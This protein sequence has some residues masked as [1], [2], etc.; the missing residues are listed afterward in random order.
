[1]GRAMSSIAFGEGRAVLRGTSRPLTRRS[2]GRPGFRWRSEASFFV[3]NF[4]SSV[5]SIWVST[6]GSFY[7]NSGGR[8]AES[9]KPGPGREGAADLRGRESEVEGV[10]RPPQ[11]RPFPEAKKRRDLRERKRAGR[12][13]DP[14]ERSGAAQ[15]ALGRA[16]KLSRTRVAGGAKEGGGFLFEW[17]RKAEER[18][19]VAA[20]RNPPR[21]AEGQREKAARE[22]LLLPTGLPPSENLLRPFPAERQ[23]EKGARHAR[24]RRGEAGDQGDSA[25][26]AR[27][28]APKEG[29]Q[30]ADAL[31]EP[32]GAHPAGGGR[33]EEL[34]PFDETPLRGHHSK[35]FR[36]FLQFRRCSARDAEPRQ[37]C[38]ETRCS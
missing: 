19:H 6:L 21:P 29:L 5:R 27:S 3:T 38:Q 28:G 9:P 36:G 1:M 20:R 37:L 11:L 17:G 31:E 35:R 2:G 25:S 23:Q 22:P 4:R 8:A 16:G 24:V 32:K 34:V 7:F 10:Q 15:D 26:R 30:G 18:S 14:A 12:L 13:Q 33:A